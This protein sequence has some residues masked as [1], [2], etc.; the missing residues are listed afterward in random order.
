MV[1]H[2]T[3]VNLEI[4]EAS[5]LA[6]LGGVKYDLRTT[7]GWC[8]QLSRIMSDRNMLWLI[9][10]LNTAILVRFM[11]AFGGGKGRY[12]DTKH[13]LSV[14][15]KEQKEQYKYFKDVRDKHF[16]HSANEFEDNQVKAYY[17]E[18]ATDKGFNDIEPSHNRVIGFSSGNISSIRN[19]CET[20]MVK[21]KSEINSERKK[22]LKITSK[23]TEKD[24]RKF[25]IKVPNRSKEIDV[26]KDRK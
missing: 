13:I 4:D 8:D 19:I 11:R 16:A 25:K 20:L 21:V 15:S 12:E 23:Y 9:E 3:Y 14:L 24:I 1:T 2:I 6:N 5:Y 18:G 26:S 22:L 10:P 7:I 17:I